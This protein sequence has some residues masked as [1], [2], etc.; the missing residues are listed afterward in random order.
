MTMMAG[1]IVYL[2][3]EATPRYTPDALRVALS[4][5]GLPGRLADDGETILLRDDKLALRLFVEDGWVMEIEIEVTFV[6]EQSAAEWL[7]DWLDAMGWA[8]ADG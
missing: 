3:D 2:A 1:T 5:S 6:D 8:R 7:C 4:Q